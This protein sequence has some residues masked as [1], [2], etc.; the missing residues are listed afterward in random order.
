MFK[1][2]GTSAWL[3]PQSPRA[4]DTVTVNPAH[5][6]PL[7]FMPSASPEKVENRYSVPNGV[8]SDGR[9]GPHREEPGCRAEPI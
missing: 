7:L 4:A 6:T 5:Q 3:I 1:F 8:E 2:H 9:C